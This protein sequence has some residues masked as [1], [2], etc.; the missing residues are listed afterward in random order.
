MPCPP[1]H[2]RAMVISDR[3]IDRFVVGKRHCRVL[4]RT[5]GRWL[6]SI[7]LTIILA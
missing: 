3:A 2:D 1:S 7:A 6:Y 4:H 5:I